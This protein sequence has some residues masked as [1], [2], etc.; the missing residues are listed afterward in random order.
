M[1]LERTRVQADLKGALA[2]DVLGGDVALQLYASDASIFEIRP[3]AVV[4]P[5]TTQDV[6][7]CLQYAHEHTIPV[8]ARGAGSGVSGESLG[9]GIVIDFSCYM[10][11]ILA[12]EEDQVTVQP[13]VVLAQLNRHLAPQGR[14]FGPDPS[15][16]SVTTMGSVLAIDSSGSHWPQYG[17]PRR[18]V[19]RLRVVLADGSVFDVDRAVPLVDDPVPRRSELSG[20]LSELLVREGQTIAAHQPKTL[21]NRGGYY[22]HGVLHDQK[23]DMASIIVGSEGTLALIVEATIATCPIPRYRGLAILFFDRLEQAALAATDVAP[24]GASACDLMDRRLMTLARESN[25]RY[26]AILPRDAEALLLVEYAGSEAAEVRGRMEALVSR[27]R[28]RRRAPFDYRLTLDPEERN[29][30]WRLARRVVPMLYRLKG[31]TRALPFV[32]DI[33][34]PPATLASFLTTIQNVLKK[35]EITASL[36]AHAIHGQIHIRP[37]LDLSR[38]EDQRKMQE[39]AE[40]LYEQVLAVG[41]TICGEHALGL[42]RTWFVRRQFGPLYDVFREVKRIFDPQNILNP[43]K[44]VAEVPQ[45]LTKNLRPVAISADDPSASRA[46]LPAL[47]LAWSAEEAMYAARSCNGCGRCRTLA[48]EERMCPLFRLATREEAAPRSKANLLRGIL[49]G[50][51]DPKVLSSEE[52]KAVTDLCFHCHQC[53]VECPASVDIPRLVAECRAQFVAANGLRFAEWLLTRLDGVARWASRLAPIANRALAHRQVRWLLERLTG[54]ASGRKLPHVTSRSFLRRAQRR[55]LHRSRRLTDN[56]VVY[57]VD[58]YAN[59]FDT[60]LAEAL[61][62]VFEHNGFTVYVPVNQTWA[63]MPAIAL[64]AMERAERL[65]RRNVSILADA[66]RQG[67]HIVTTEP[68]ALMCLRHEYVQLLNDDDA[69]LVASHASDACDFLW[70]LHQQNRLALDFTPLR[71][72]LGYH[73]P[74][75]LRAFSLQSAGE[76][77]LRLIPGLT[78]ERI[79]QGCSGMAGTWGLLRKNYRSSLRIGWGLISA[80]REPHVQAGSSE[81]STCRL[82]IEQGSGKPALHPIKLLALAYSLLPDTPDRWT[83]RASDELVLR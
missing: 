61:V 19:R 34:V 77:L 71:V 43:G 20:R 83:M 40:D 68:A 6:V 25:P 28:R 74:C 11:R 66:V 56:K 41:G 35:H 39:L 65:A 59:W 46:K 52:V 75:H 16:R 42:S 63:G 22:L 5:R 53:R 82:Q 18:H 62:A 57:F 60:E 70:Q 45:P 12:V 23:L 36:F 51:L 78:V 79:D 54:I 37:F 64:G 67:Y 73:L 1:D 17:S 21:V 4:R 8:H 29:F 3:L 33:A 69:R 31:S 80:M 24:T 38:P 26:D 13:G 10:R 47:Q 15:T 50:R 48:P 27:L 7:A 58:L 14:L 9:P 30:Y 55:R 32:E 72:S 49:S 44:V 81:C 2:C 76:N